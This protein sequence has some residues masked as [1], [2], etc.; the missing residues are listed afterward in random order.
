MFV[1]FKNERGGLSA[2]QVEGDPVAYG[3]RVVPKGVPFGFAEKADFPE[4]RD[5]RDAWTVDDADLTA[6]YGERE[7]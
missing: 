6:G 5:Q 4:S 7:Q 1:I 2:S 3:K